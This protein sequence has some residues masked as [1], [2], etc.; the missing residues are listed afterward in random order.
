MLYRVK[1]GCNAPAS[2]MGM[3][4]YFRWKH[5]KVSEDALGDAKVD[6]DAWIHENVKDERGYLPVALMLQDWQLY[7]GKN[8]EGVWLVD[9]SNCP[10]L[11]RWVAQL[12]RAGRP[13]AVAWLK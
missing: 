10:C 2:F 12:G 6:K 11:Y 13:E 9:T 7:I 1:D 8:G 5:G 3:A 4:V